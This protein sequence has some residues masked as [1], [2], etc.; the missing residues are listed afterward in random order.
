MDVYAVA[1]NSEADGPGLIEALLHSANSFTVTLRDAQGEPLAPREE[2]VKVL[3]V[4]VGDGQ[5]RLDVSVRSGQ[6]GRFDVSYVLPAVAEGEGA[7]PDELTVSVL[8]CGQHVRR[9][10][11][12]VPVIKLVP[13]APVVF[14]F[15]RL[16]NASQTTYDRASNTLRE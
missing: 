2:N 16:S 1:G 12:R 8:V 3:E 6:G 4:L 11:F 13:V 15:D 7:A 14:D 10:P 5:R 9:S